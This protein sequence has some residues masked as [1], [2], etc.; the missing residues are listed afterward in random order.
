MEETIVN[1]V[2]ESGLITLNLEE[3]YHQGERVLFD[4]A[5]LLFQG[6]IL[7]E[8]DFRDY[9]KTHDWSSYQGKNVA[10]ICSADAIVPTWAYMLLAVNLAPHAH[11]VVFGNLEALEQALFSDAIAAID[12]EQFR[13]A[14]VIIKG[15]SNVPVPIFAYTEL[16]RRLQPVV[17]SLMYGEACSNVPLYKRKKS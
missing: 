17:Q 6:L 7:R 4:L 5:P 14:R 13:G 10:I 12:I 8:K 2:A 1:R 9:V 3:H 16:T 11:K 15:C